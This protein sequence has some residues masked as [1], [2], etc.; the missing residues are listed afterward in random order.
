MTWRGSYA[1][2]SAWGSSHQA[3]D[4]A[5][6]ECHERSDGAEPAPR[7]RPE[8]PLRADPVSERP[9]QPVLLIIALLPARDVAYI[10]D[11]CRRPRVHADRRRGKGRQGRRGCG[12]TSTE[13]RGREA[14]NRG[15]FARAPALAGHIL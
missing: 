4:G 13:G 5:G 3:P 2:P 14:R 10:L 6:L 11:P 15:Y 8:P 12:L 7:P 1:S 9:D